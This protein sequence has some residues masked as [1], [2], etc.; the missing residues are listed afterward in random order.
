M[1]DDDKALVEA[2]ERI[3]YWGMGDEVGKA[4]D[5]IEALREALTR[6]AYYQ[7]SFADN[8]VSVYADMQYIAR[9]ALGETK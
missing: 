9:A 3:D 6:V 1:T 2:L 5:R 4:A 7:V 8:P